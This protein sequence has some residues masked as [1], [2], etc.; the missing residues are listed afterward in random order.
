MPINSAYML[1]VMINFIIKTQCEHSTWE[2]GE[3][4]YEKWLEM[5]WKGY[6]GNVLSELN[7]VG[8]RRILKETQMAWK[9]IGT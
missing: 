1:I 5:F 2:H 3:G 4:N 7:G 8:V 9:C 6:A